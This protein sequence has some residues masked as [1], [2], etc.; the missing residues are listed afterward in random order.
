[1]PAKS[2]KKDEQVLF[3]FTNWHVM[4]HYLGQPSNCEYT[5]RADAGGWDGAPTQNVI[6]N[7]DDRHR[8]DARGKVPIT[9][10]RVCTE[11]LKA[12]MGSRFGSIKSTRRR[13]RYAPKQAIYF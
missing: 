13:D 12:E 9:F 2:K 8:T 5:C 7:S 6:I 10:T 11:K 4:K 3:A 1:M